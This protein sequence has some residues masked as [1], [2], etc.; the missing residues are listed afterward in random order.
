MRE[1]IIAGLKNALERGESLE[2]A[3]QSFINAG[4]NPAEVRE[5][6]ESLSQGSMS[7]SNPE[8]ERLQLPAPRM[9]LPPPPS[10][11]M[12]SQQMPQQL[13]QMQASYKR[14]NDIRPMPEVRRGHGKR[15]ALIIILIIILLLLI[16]GL[17]FMIFYGQ[18][19]LDKILGQA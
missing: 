5:A 10:L 16:G 12:P 18:E 19:F 1:D 14:L 4:Y 3:V 2:K 6:A 11:Q 9:Q 7:I 8:A 15:T 17:I 13:P